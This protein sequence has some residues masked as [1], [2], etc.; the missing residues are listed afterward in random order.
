[1]QRKKLLD[2]AHLLII[3]PQHIA[4]FDD[5]EG[6]PY[7]ITLSI[8]NHSHRAMKGGSFAGHTVAT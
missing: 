8:S 6:A 5:A 4:A 2:L 3:G 7:D 1:M